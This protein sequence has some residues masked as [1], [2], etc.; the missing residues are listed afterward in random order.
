M[1]QK[2]FSL[3]HFAVLFFSVEAS[4]TVK[5]L[6]LGDSI[7]HGYTSRGGYRYPL[8]KLL[9]NRGISIDFVGSQSSKRDSFFDGNDVDHEGHLGWRIDQISAKVPEWMG[10][11]KPD[12]VLLMIGTND[13][14]QKFDVMRAPQRLRSLV[15]KILM[16]D[17]QVRV[18]VG[19]LFPAKLSMIQDPNVNR[20]IEQDLEFFNLEAKK[21]L[22]GLSPRVTLVD[23]NANMNALTMTVDGIHPTQLAYEEIARRWAIALARIL[24]TE[25]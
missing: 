5:I 1:R 8:E 11:Q 13:V 10:Y 14:Y 23:M 12:V 6:P 9:D 24:R 22:A 19:S 25:P 15:Q 4:A 20:E 17:P 7:T 3:L 16:L 21:Q 18:V 2:I